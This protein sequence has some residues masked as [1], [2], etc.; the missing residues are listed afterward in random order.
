[1]SKKNIANILL[2]FSLAISGVIGAWLVTHQRPETIVKGDSKNFSFNFPTPL[3][4][5]KPKPD[6]TYTDS[7]GIS[8]S[9]PSDMTV[10]DIT[11]DDNDHY[12]VLSI[13]KGNNK[14]T[15]QARDT[16]IQSLEDWLAKES[17][18]LY[19]EQFGSVPL[20]GLLA[21]Q[22]SK[23]EKFFTAAVDN[24]VLYLI[25]GSNSPPFW[26][27]IQ[28]MIVSTFTF[29]GGDVLTASNTSSGQN[30]IYEEEYVE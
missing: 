17:E 6:K 5:Y 1:M 8:F 13:E 7:A 4:E 29:K 24:D 3:P 30:I 23:N 12:T 22:Y 28:N 11:P 20:G 25:Q 15:I 14:I 26:I 10:I 18:S 27:D 21:K 9:Y 19:F 16:Q 2:T